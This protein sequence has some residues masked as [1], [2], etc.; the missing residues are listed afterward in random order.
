[1][2][3]AFSQLKTA[4]LR[5]PLPDKIKVRITQKFSGAGNHIQLLPLN[6]NGKAFQALLLRV[7]VVLV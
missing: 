6:S 4:Q 5:A 2:F 1:M 7:I 3:L